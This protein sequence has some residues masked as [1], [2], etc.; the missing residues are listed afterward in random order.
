MVVDVTIAPFAFYRCRM[1]PTPEIR[2]RPFLRSVVACAYVGALGCEG[3]TTLSNVQH[4]SR[5]VAQQG[6]FISA[7][8]G[9][10]AKV[11][12]VGWRQRR[13]HTEKGTLPGCSLSMVASVKVTEGVLFSFS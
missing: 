6:K 11:Q 4:G 12:P 10:L 5:V 3:L 8:I 7:F 13:G 1:T 9:S 2:R